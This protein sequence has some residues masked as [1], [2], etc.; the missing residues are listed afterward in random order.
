MALAFK[1]KGIKEGELDHYIAYNLVYSN[2]YHE[3]VLVTKMML[4]IFPEASHLHLALARVYELLN[5]NDLALSSYR[6]AFLYL[7]EK[8][9]MAI[10]RDAIDRSQTFE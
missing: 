8:G 6:K 2:R 4:K 5:N 1:D 7:E 3:A 9:K 10:F